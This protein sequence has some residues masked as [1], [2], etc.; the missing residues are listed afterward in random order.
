M[1][2][3]K[4]RKKRSAMMTMMMMMTMIRNVFAFFQPASS[5]HE[6]WGSVGSVG[7]G[8]GLCLEDRGA[9]AAAYL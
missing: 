1:T 5:D 4:S 9:E 3:T 8:C 6:T 2:K 7:C